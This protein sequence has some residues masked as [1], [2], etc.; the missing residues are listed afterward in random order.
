MSRYYTF[1][2]EVYL[3]FMV[4]WIDNLEPRLLPKGTIIADEIEELNEMYFIMKGRA[5]VGFEVNK[6]K[7]YCLELRDHFV[8]GS[9]AT[10]FDHTSEFIYTATKDCFGMSIRQVRM[11]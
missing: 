5:A 10:V 2:D 1:E 9:H 3:N 7:K 8:I 11:K 6:V 4:Q